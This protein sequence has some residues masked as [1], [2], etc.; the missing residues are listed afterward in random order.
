MPKHGDIII[1]HRKDVC[2]PSLVRCG[3]AIR[4]DRARSRKDF[5]FTEV[6]TGKSIDWFAWSLR[7][8]DWTYA[9]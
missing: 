8:T 1:I 4:L 6:A 7:H 9:A 2:G 3:V 5:R